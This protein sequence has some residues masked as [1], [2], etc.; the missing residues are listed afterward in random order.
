M[1]YL[2]RYLVLLISLNLS[3]N[4]NIIEKRVLALLNIVKMS[5][6]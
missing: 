6:Y 4:M 2:E 5:Q 1:L 3:T